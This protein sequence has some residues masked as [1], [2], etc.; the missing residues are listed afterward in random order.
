MQCEHKALV[1]KMTDFDHVQTKVRATGLSVVGG[2][3]VDADDDL[4][5]I[6]TLLLLG[7]DSA[8]MWAAFQDSH[9]AT[10]ERSNPLDR[11]SSRVVGA[12]ASELGA[13]PFLPFGGPPWHPFQKWA[14][15]GE[16][17]TS[18]PVI[19]QATPTRGLWASY[20]GALGFANTLALPVWPDK[21]PCA[22]CPAPCK[23]ACPVDAFSDGAYD[24]PRC[25]AHV[26]SPEGSAC[27]DGCLVRSVCPAGKALDLPLAQR[28]FHMEAFLRANG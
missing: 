11:W 26:Q 18:S 10:A 23:T 15:R 25:T 1:T 16:A 24:V 13:R 22:P 20:R 14:A 17:A 7:S 4:P 28:Q 2:F 21:A 9:E 27:R 19:M 12:L 5:N 8:D 6:A 3:H